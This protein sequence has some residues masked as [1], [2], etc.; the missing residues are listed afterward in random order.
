M[1]IVVLFI[2]LTISFCGF[3]NVTVDH[4]LA[5]SNNITETI[6]PGITLMITLVS[7]IISYCVY[8]VKQQERYY[9]EFKSCSKSLYS[10][11]PIE[12]ASAAILMRGFLKKRR[13]GILFHVDYT[14]EA[15]NLLVALLKTTIPINLQKNLSDGFSY[16][17]S[18]EGQ[19]MQSINMQG[20]LIKPES[21]IKYELTKD[22]KYN[23]KRLS[24]KNVDLFHAV[25][26]EC[27]INNVDASSAIF[28]YTI[29]CGTSFKNCVFVGAKFDYANISRTV[30]DDD[31]IM[32]KASFKNAVG[33][34]EA[35]VK[36]M[37]NGVVE[38]HK[39]IE[40]LDKD[41]IF[42]EK[43][44]SNYEIPER[45]LRVFVSKLG[46]MNSQQKLRYD[47]MVGLLGDEIE[48]D[49]IERINYLNT[50]QL[51]DVDTHLAQCDG[52]IIFAF[53][54]LDVDHGNIHRNVVGED[55]QEIENKIFAS[56]WLHIETAL[57]NGKQMPCMV[58]CDDKLCRDGM[59]DE[60]IV[61]PDKNMF[62]INYSDNIQSM[63]PTLLEWKGKV[64]EFHSN[65]HSITPLPK[66]TGLL[67]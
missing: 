32:E 53:E 43:K 66:T 28:L 42:H 29:L 17:N 23:K 57:A 19:D 1:R 6:I 40:F 11:N 44:S 54:Y 63:E 35:K 2:I 61:N 39:L 56:P 45:K 25:V 58:V 5:T 60:A 18:L 52:C 67:S 13:V 50:S 51:I 12:Q 22:K 64:V 38:S 21:R 33:I 16:A 46:V 3:G 62:I 47:M 4:L 37:I 34:N 59:F 49:S 27:S 14:K 8:I 41:G 10:D 7:A 9:Q 55:N 30:F 48:L 24:M 15:V 36:R 26:Q 20:A 31:C 65:H